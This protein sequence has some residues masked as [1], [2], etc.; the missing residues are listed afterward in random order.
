MARSP[1]PQAAYSPAA[2]V[3]SERNGEVVLRWLFYALAIIQLIFGLGFL[4]IPETVGSQYGSSMNATAVAI[5]RYW[6]SS[7]VGL[8]WISWMAA[9]AMASPLKLVIVRASALAS[10]LGLVVT[11]IAYSAGVI[12]TGGLV[13][14]IVLTGVFLVGFAYYGWMRTS[15]T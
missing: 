3:G 10:L 2:S 5:A 1:V 7:L 15:E 6:A 8:A 4:V 14:N 13:V 12:N 11:F 9:S